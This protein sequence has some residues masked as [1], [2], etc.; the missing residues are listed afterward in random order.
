[1]FFNSQSQIV[2]TFRSSP[3]PRPV[4]AAL[5]EPKDVGEFFRNF[6]IKCALNI[7]PK[8]VSQQ[9]APTSLPRKSQNDRSLRVFALR[10]PNVYVFVPVSMVVKLFRIRLI[11]LEN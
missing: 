6:A 9:L 7:G 3:I 1:M 11:V 2:M 8:V 5:F 10:K 4:F